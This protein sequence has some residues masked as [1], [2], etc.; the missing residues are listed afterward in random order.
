MTTDYLNLKTRHDQDMDNN[1]R[2]VAALS[3]E[4]NDLQ[5]DL[6]ELKGQFD[7]LQKLNRQLRAKEKT[8]FVIYI[9]ICLAGFVLGMRYIFDGMR[10]SEF[11]INA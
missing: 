4:K 11:S 8:S 10:L 9:C 6:L 2:Q 7:S 5:K 1:G 3:R